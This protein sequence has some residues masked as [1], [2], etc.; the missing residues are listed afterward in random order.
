MS[1][2]K[3]KIAMQKI[4][5]SLNNESFYIILNGNKNDCGS[6]LVNLKFEVLHKSKKQANKEVMC[7][8]RLAVKRSEMLELLSLFL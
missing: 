8:S 4:E 3:K 6:D 7:L 5:T 2:G 1:Y